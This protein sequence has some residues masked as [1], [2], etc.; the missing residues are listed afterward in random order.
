MIWNH[1]NGFRSQRIPPNSKVAT[2]PNQIDS[3]RRIADES[4][5][6]GSRTSRH[7]SIEHA[8]IEVINPPKAAF[9]PSCGVMSLG[10]SFTVFIHAGQKRAGEYH[11][12]PIIIRTIAV[13]NIPRAIIPVIII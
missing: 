3:P 8:I 6:I 7:A 1:E 9:I 12:K 5:F 2:N 10:L 4:V 13:I 11:A